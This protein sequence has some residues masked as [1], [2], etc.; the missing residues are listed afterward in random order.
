[1]NPTSEQNEADP[2]KKKKK[3]KKK[4]KNMPCMNQVQ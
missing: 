2:A 4:K 3:K 1:M